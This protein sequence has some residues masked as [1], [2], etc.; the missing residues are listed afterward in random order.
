MNT[1]SAV[2]AL[3]ALSQNHRLAAFRALVQAGPDGLSVGALRA[4]LELPAA[5]LSA[6]LNRL[7]A[8]GLVTDRRDGRTIH[9]SAHFDHMD[10]LLGFLTENCCA[11]ATCSTSYPSQK[12]R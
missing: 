8:A 3:R 11:G 9:V 4:R 10:A 7:R 1:E 6:H 12:S 5:T 2:L